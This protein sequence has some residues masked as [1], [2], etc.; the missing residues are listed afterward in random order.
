MT[1]A[2]ATAIEA[3]EQEH[4]NLLLEPATMWA[5]ED[6]LVVHAPGFVAMLLASGELVKS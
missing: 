5:G 4:G 2:Q 3:L 1:T 6:R